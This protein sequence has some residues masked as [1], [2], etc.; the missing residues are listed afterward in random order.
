S[1]CN[2]EVLLHQL[3]AASAVP[4]IAAMQR[5]MFRHWA[6]AEDAPMRASGA[7]PAPFGL[8]FQEGDSLAMNSTCRAHYSEGFSK[9]SSKKID[10]KIPAGFY[11]KDPADAASCLQKSNWD[12]PDWKGLKTT[13]ALAADQGILDKHHRRCTKNQDLPQ[14]AREKRWKKCFKQ[15]DSQKHNVVNWEQQSVVASTEF[16]LLP[17]GWMIDGRKLPN[18]KLPKPKCTGEA[19]REALAVKESDLAATFKASVIEEATPLLMAVIRQ[20]GGASPSPRGAKK[21]L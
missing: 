11:P 15:W 13:Y 19:Y 16:S 14:D 17:A 20:S 21:L 3:S 12:N 18:G 2:W 6:I 1:L 9:D 4:S 8:D 5:T 7:N 10:Q